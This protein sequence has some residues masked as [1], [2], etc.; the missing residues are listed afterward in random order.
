MPSLQSIGGIPPRQSGYRDTDD[1]EADLDA[2]YALPNLDIVALIYVK[3]AMLDAVG[4]FV[5][6]I[7]NYTWIP[8][9][10]SFE[11]YNAKKTDLL[12]RSNELL[13][14]VVEINSIIRSKQVL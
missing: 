4:R 6:E 10:E 12:N 9:K 11:S 3:N 8:E 5:D 14:K 7:R 2:R 13:Y 1:N